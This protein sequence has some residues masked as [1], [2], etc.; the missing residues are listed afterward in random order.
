MNIMLADDCHSGKCGR[1]SID[2]PIGRIP[3][4][5]RSL[6]VVIPAVVPYV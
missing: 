3:E 5:S 2:G 6:R 1:A 4:V